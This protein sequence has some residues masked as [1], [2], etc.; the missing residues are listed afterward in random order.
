MRALVKF[1]RTTPKAQIPIDKR[2]KEWRPGRAR[3]GRLYA[4]KSRIKQETATRPPVSNS[5]AARARGKCGKMKPAVIMATPQAMP[6]EVPDVLPFTMT[7]IASALTP[8][9]TARARQKAQSTTA[10]WRRRSQSLLRARGPSLPLSDNGS[11]SAEP[12]SCSAR[13]QTSKSGRHREPRC[14]DICRAGAGRG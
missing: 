7:L 2:T 10:P 6:A 11:E 13:L 4:T 14:R 8:S 3:S 12:S 9:R 1:S 5:T